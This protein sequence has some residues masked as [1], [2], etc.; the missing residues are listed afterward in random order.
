MYVSCRLVLF[1]QTTS[2][3]GEDSALV[4]LIILYQGWDFQHPVFKFQTLILT[5]D[6]VECVEQKNNVAGV[7]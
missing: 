4:F 3:Q 6:Q 1:N 2:H 5:C 7:D